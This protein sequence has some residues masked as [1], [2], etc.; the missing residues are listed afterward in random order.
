MKTTPTTTP[1]TPVSLQERP[2]VMAQP[3]GRPPR[4]M[5]VVWQLGA[6]PCMWPPL[7]Q[8]HVP[9]TLTRSLPR[10]INVWTCC[11]RKEAGVGSAAV[12]R[13]CRTETGDYGP[14][15]SGWDPFLEAWEWVTTLSESLLPVPVYAGIGP[16]GEG[17]TE[18]FLNCW[19][20]KLTEDP[21]S[22]KGFMLFFSEQCLNECS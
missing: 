15:P 7:P 2:I 5:T 21:F 14:R 10:S 8:S 6:L 17:F 20:I 22:G 18:G 16:C 9:T 19:P 4:P 3:R 13:A 11:P 1:R 12:G